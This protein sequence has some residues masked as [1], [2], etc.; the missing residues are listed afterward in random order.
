VRTL[1]FLVRFV[2]LLTVGV[3]MLSPGTALAWSPY[4][5]RD[6]KTWTEPGSPYEC[7]KDALRQ[8]IGLERARGE[9]SAPSQARV[10]LRSEDK[11][12][13]LPCRERSSTKT[14][15]KGVLTYK[16]EA[17]R[18]H[19]PK[20]SCAVSGYS[21]CATLAYVTWLPVRDL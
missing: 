21:Q 6:H 12:K 8:I 20:Q 1:Q 11:D 19:L 17:T 14:N 3:L 16:D 7:A 13:P 9:P 15:G 5:M 2:A 18:K 4:G 10:Q